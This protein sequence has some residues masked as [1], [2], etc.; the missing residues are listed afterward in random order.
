MQAY[1]T[2]IISQATAGIMASICKSTGQHVQIM[3]E[4]KFKLK[5]EHLRRQIHAN[6]HEGVLV[7]MCVHMC[8]KVVAKYSIKCAE[9]A[10]LAPAS[11]ARL[12]PNTKIRKSD[13]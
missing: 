3:K 5:V 6:C 12:F 11:I 1:R 4:C 10:S 9:V 13:D 8:A 7:Y 2:A